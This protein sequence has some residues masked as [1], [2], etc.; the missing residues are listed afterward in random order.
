MGHNV[1]EDCTTPLSPAILPYP[2]LS[3]FDNSIL[4]QHPDEIPFLDLTDGVSTSLPSVSSLRYA[5]PSTSNRNITTAGVMSGAE[6][7]IGTEGSYQ[8]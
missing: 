4:L 1:S 8:A 2:D 6:A 7:N 3:E 5:I